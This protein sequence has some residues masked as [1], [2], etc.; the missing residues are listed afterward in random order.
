MKA[1]HL[2]IHVPF[3]ARR[4]SY[5]DF[6]IAVRRAVPVDEFVTSVARELTIR[7]ADAEAWTLD[8]LYLGGGTPSRLGPDGVA[9]LIDAVRSRATLAPGA[10][11]TLEAN[12]EDVTAD[13]AR[14]WS[15]AGVSRLSI[16]A[17]SFDDA[18]LRWMHRT[19]DAAAIAAA[20]ESARAAGIDNYSLDLIFALPPGI[21]RSWERDVSQA[22]ALQPR[23]LSL[24]GLTVEPRTPLGRRLARRE[25]TESPDE[26]YAREFLYAHEALTSTGFDHYEISNFAQPGWHSRHNSA[27][28]SGTPYVGLGP[29]AHG[30]DGRVRRWNVEAYVDWLRRVGENGDP[31]GGSERLTPPSQLVEEVYL[32]LRTAAGVPLKPAESSSVQSWIEA[33]WAKSDAVDR[34]VLTASGWLRMD[35]LA[36]AL[37]SIRSR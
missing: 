2:Y 4:C 37:T 15:R 24:Y 27:Y 1:P 9:R 19:H 16:G 29:S 34:L 11:V 13:A 6:S 26:W 23:H 7:F 18:V 33:G 30:F 8:T 17:Q 31:L 32:G 5:C 35:G 3:C 10:E 36:A 12:P 21:V 14:A 28:W 25:I 20:V 22:L